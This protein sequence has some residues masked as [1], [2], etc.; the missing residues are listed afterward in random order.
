MMSLPWFR[1]YAEFAG[2]P[3]IQS[4]AFEDQRHYVVLLC[5]KCDG[6]LDRQIQTQIRN[7]IICRALGLDPVTAAE[8]KKRLMEVR[9][10]DEKWQPFGWN[11]RQYKSDVSTERV[12]KCRKSKETGNVS[13]TLRNSF[14]NAPDT[15]TDTEEENTTTD[16]VVVAKLAT[17]P[18]QEIIALYHQHLPM[19]T[20]V[21]IWN[22]NRQKQLQARWREDKQ[23][24]NLDWW[25]KFFDYLSQSAFLTGQAG[26]RPFTINLPW[27]V[28]AENFAKCLEGNYHGGNRAQR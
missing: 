27:I 28:K 4:L 9:L 6:T 7:R 10:I 15:D 1:L 26:D 25:D 20:S 24:Q 18:H 19:G 21:R 23:R 11:K 3:V 2:D 5:L 22:G 16:V 12:R 13:E 17:C 8:A 14:G